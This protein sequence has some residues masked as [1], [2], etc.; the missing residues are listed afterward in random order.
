M[1]LTDHRVHMLECEWGQSFSIDIFLEDI[2]SIETKYK[3]DVWLL[4]LAPFLVL[5]SFYFGSLYG[6]EIATLAG[7]ILGSLAIAMWW[8]TRK[9]QLS[10][11][12]NGGTPINF[13]LQGMSMDKINDLVQV[14]LLAKQ[15]RV[16]AL[17]KV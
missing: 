5:G 12:S 3:S 13:N 4:I 7:I 10:I 14:I 15:T 17:N 8:A 16:N 9:R 11:S 2:S 6:G 1:I